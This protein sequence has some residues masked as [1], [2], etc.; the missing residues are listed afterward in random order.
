[1]SFVEFPFPEPSDMEE[2]GYR[3]FPEI[4]ES[5]PLILFHATRPESFN[6]ILQCGFKTAAELGIVGGL[7]SVTYAKQSSA[8]LGH[9]R[10]RY[11]HEEVI[12][13]AVEFSAVKARHG[14]AVNSSDIH[15]Y[16]GTQPNI[17][18]ICRVPEGYLFV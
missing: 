2:L 14:M 10:D 15:V 3:V 6:E 9:I 4:M 11:R 17:I 8:A 5:N 18:G 7:A 1:M 16:D 12:I 13:I